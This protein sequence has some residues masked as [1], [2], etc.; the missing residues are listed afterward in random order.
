MKD[1][2]KSL[3]TKTKYFSLS[4]SNCCSKYIYVYNCGDI[5]EFKLIRLTMRYDWMHE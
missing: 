1:Y 2:E 3:R 4:P 5:L